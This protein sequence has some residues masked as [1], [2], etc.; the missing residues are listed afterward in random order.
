[1]KK[2][3]ILIPT[4]N[5]L[6]AL[7]V[8]LTSLYYQTE[9][10]FD[11]IIADQSTQDDLYTDETVQTIIRLLETEGHAITILKNLP[12]KGLAQQRAFLLEQAKTNYSLYLDD[13]LI[14]EPYVVKN[15]LTV[16][17][18]QQCGFVGC[19]VIGLSYKDSMRQHQQAIEFWNGV[20]EPECVTPGTKAWERYVLHNAANI[21]HVQQKLQAKPD[22]PRPYKVAWVGGCVMYNTEKLLNTGGFS[23]WHHLPEK[24]CGEDV[25][26]QLKVMKRYGGCGIIPSGVYHQERETTVKERN[27]NAPEYLQVE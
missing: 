22:T 16:I 15:M 11:I 26:A 12:R 20:V 27:I 4:Y 7:S 24:H 13:D 2:I 25:L 8:T 18:Q 3:A 21:Y 5:R 1:M 17:E 10:D 23:F 14:L 6:Q 19:A 9:K